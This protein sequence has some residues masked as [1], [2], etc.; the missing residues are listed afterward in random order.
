MFDGSENSPVTQGAGAAAARTSEDA[1]MVAAADWAA[2]SY[3]VEGRDAQVETLPAGADG[4]V[5]LV[6]VPSLRRVECVLHDESDFT[7]VARGLD[8]MRRSGWAVWILAPLRRLGDAHLAFRG[9]ADYLQGWW[10]R[11]DESVT[12]TSP[13][14]P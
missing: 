7:A 13:Q 3:R 14:V 1:A 9:E 6:V 11:P 10:V 8:E 5:R 2:L 4:D 12:F